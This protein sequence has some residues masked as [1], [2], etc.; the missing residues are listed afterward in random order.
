[1]K[2]D[3]DIALELITLIEGL[4]LREVIYQTILGT[5]TDFDWQKALEKHETNGSYKQRVHEQFLPLREQVLNAP[6][7][8]A[9]VR[10]MLNFDLPDPPDQN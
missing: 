3:K 10:D 5:V 2:T 7:L 9:A 1:M 4:H 6:D 8:T